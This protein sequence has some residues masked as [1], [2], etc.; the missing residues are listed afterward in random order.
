M[1]I[2]LKNILLTS[3]LL[4]AVSPLAQAESVT[5]GQRILVVVSELDGRGMPELR[6]LY[7]ALEDLT[8]HTVHALLQDKY[9]EIVTLQ[10]G[11]AT[12]PNL[13]RTLLQLAQRPEIKAIDMI[14]S[15][16]GSPEKLSFSEGAVKKEDIKNFIL[17][18]NTRQEQVAKIMMKKKLRMLYNLACYAGRNISELKDIGFD[19]VNGAK[20]VNANSEV[21][22]V[23]AMTAWANGM[24]FMNSFLGTNNPVALAIADGPIR[25]AGVL[26]N[27]ALKET[28]SEKIFV[29][30]TDLTIHSL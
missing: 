14:V 19:V 22:F 23:P 30:K 6:P 7:R 13:K 3:A 10:D 18:T 15:L 4:F 25:A 2:S 11:R 17:E 16:H 28:N 9:A 8:T 5:R 21:E 24:G 26:A 29:G 27:N 12:L 1:K 20:G